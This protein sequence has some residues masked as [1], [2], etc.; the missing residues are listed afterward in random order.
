M[1]NP[2]CLISNLRCDYL[3]NPLGIDNPFPD[4]SWK[5]LVS[6]LQEEILQKSY[7]ILVASSPGLL[8]KGQGDLWDSGRIESEQSTHVTYA[9]RSLTSRQQ[10]FWKVIVETSEGVLVPSDMARWSM[11]LLQVLDWKAQWIGLDEP[12]Q[13]PEPWFGAAEW[14]WSEEKRREGKYATGVHW[15]YTEFEIPEELSNAPLDVWAY[16][17]DSCMIYLNDSNVA[18]ATPV[19][20]C[21]PTFY[22]YAAPLRQR[23]S[24][25]L[26][27]GRHRLALR[28]VHSEEENRPAGVILRLQIQKGEHC[29]QVVTTKLWKHLPGQQALSSP[30]GFCAAKE[31]VSLGA[32]GVSPWNEV[33]PR[34]FRHLPA[35]YLRQ[36]FEIPMKPEQAMVYLSGLGHFELYINGQRVGNDVLVPNLTDYEK[37]VYY[38]TYDIGS[39]LKTGKNAVGVILGNGWFFAARDRMPFAWKNFGCPKMI[40]QLELKNNQG[41]DRLVSSDVS[42]KISAEGPLGWNNLFDGETY[43]ARREM[44]GWCEIGF[45]DRA[46]KS[47]QP[48]VR[49]LG[50]LS[51]QMS[52]PQ[53][54]METLRP[55]SVQ[56]KEAQRRI[57]DLG[58]NI[59]GWSQI[60]LQGSEHTRI[61]LRHAEKV[62]QKGDLSI[63]N[64][65]S[66]VCTNSIQLSGQALTYEPRFVYHGFRYVEVVAEPGPLPSLELSGRVVHDD[67]RTTGSFS[68]SNNQL[69]QNFQAISR[70][71]RGNYH[72][73]PTDCP[74]RDERLGWLGDRGVGCVGEMYLFDVAA[75]YRKW[76]QDFADAQAPNGSIPDIAPAYWTMYHDN[77]TWPGCITFI[78]MALYRHYGDTATI[79]RH[80][81]TMQRW[82]DH[83]SG[84]M[85]RGLISRDTWGDW[86]VP[87]ESPELIHSNDPQ[88]KTDPAILASCYFYRNLQDLAFFAR[89]TGRSSD[90]EKYTSLAES[91]RQEFNRTF[92]HLETAQYGN[93]SQ[94]SCVLPLALGLAPE[95]IQ[96]ALFQ[97]LLSNLCTP[98]GP[99]LGVGM[100]GIQWIMRELSRR[101]R[102]DVA[103]A[104][105]TRQ[106][107]PSWG[108]MLKDGGT[109]LWELWN[110]DSAQ[111][112]MNSGNHVMLT[113]DLHTWMFECLGGI[114]TNL[115]HPGFKKI[116]LEPD[117]SCPLDTVAVSYDSMHG[118]I[119]SEWE[120]SG[121]RL[122]WS[123]SIP[124]NTRAR[125]ALE[126]LE[127]SSVLVNGKKIKACSLAR[128]NL[129][130]GSGDYRITGNLSS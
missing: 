101:G 89:L 88:R 4:L 109:T 25:G 44:P 87:P 34:E 46:W 130:L 49:P 21:H 74:Q 107:Y 110:G 38:C 14:I 37:R 5:M 102:G 122:S 104:L 62:D 26:P 2:A 7:Q 77:V 92:L 17:D 81:L 108:Y 15:F 112:F 73:V 11:G 118:L 59:V 45:D 6:G 19:M 85:Q 71:L 48:V 75:L 53:R 60:Q 50:I 61:L 117:F 90:Q 66:A 69:N 20:V 93:G 91:L 64:L 120:K 96:E 119:R 78:P 56:E 100:I 16:G 67:V 105:A 65:R 9:G 40:F 83:M 70:G 125:L 124:A 35:R 31:A 68:S 115:S 32:F 95:K 123:I 13:H 97:R 23:I 30:P 36:E 22:L 10:C 126:K 12:S 114:Q 58:K 29:M 94:T 116:I 42:W 127:S 3:C 106:D 28:A 82:V 63:D 129:E 33:T 41:E 86:C 128:T 103:Y 84:Y 55:V 113:G 52:E 99:I 76:V 111:P 72:N 18:Q 57:Y 121:Q 1:M 51:A 27:A 79:R 54:V 43:D 8:E 80:Y 24:T 98:Q 39:Y 47:A